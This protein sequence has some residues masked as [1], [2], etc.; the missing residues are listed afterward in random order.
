MRA[1]VIDNGGPTPYRTRLWLRGVDISSM[2]T[3]Y[4]IDQ[5]P[6]SLTHCH[7]DIVVWPGNISIGARHCDY[8]GQTS[9]GEDARG[10]CLACGAPR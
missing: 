8:C 3:A 6:N 9:P 1:L 4:S 2:V 10:G 7:I 5:A